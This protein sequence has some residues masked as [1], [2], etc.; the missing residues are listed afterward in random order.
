MGSTAVAINPR[1]FV[2]AGEA[3]GDAYCA[4]LIKELRTLEPR[5]KFE[6]IGGRR[7][8][9][10]ISVLADSSDWGAIGIW[11]SL[12]VASRAVSA[13]YAAKRKLA[14]GKPGLFIPIDFGYMN[15]RLARQAKR[16]GWK[17]LYFIPPGSW[18]R[19]KQGADLPSVTDAISTPFPWSAEILTKMGANARWFGHPIK[20]FI[21]E[22]YPSVRG[23]TVAVLPGSRRHEID[24]NLPVIARAVDGKV[25]FALAPGIDQEEF[26][27]RWER[28]RPSGR[29]DIV[30]VGDT[31]GVLSRS[32][33]AIVCSGTATLEAALTRTPMVV[34]YRVT[35]AMVLESKLRLFKLPRFISL[36]NIV[37]DR[38]VVPELI[39]DDAT[40]ESLR[41]ALKPLLLDGPERAA[42]LG[43]FEEI[44]TL[45]GP[46]DGITQTAKLA[47]ELLGG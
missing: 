5:L 19:H 29:D 45:A 11:Q 2:S 20:Q 33:A 32:Q 26:R 13:Y 25:E 43:A 7:V 14:A 9:A 36:P 31:T 17:V 23:D 42:Q 44:D 16:L 8:R 18:R 1:I 40:P 47:L 28:L 3:S 21:V 35:R 27:A 34:I 46:S 12:L 41:A 4:A 30:T 22:T 10:S 24:S 37:L 15:I 6:G 39:Q 38:E